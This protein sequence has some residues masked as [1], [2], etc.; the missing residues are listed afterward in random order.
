MRPLHTA[1]DD[2]SRLRASAAGV[3]GAFGLRAADR[4]NGKLAELPVEKA[5][6]GTLLALSASTSVYL[7]VDSSRF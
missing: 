6:I 2:R 7:I 5:V 4:I 3:L 1:I